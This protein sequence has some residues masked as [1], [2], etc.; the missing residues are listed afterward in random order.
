M[1]TATLGSVDSLLR[2]T[3]GSVAS[4]LTATI[5]SVASMFTAI[6]YQGNS[7]DMSHRLWSF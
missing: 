1:L 2:A 4:L 6:L 5:G 7:D 3:L